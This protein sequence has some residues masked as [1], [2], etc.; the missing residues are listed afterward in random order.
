MHQFTSLPFVYFSNR[1]KG[2]TSRIPINYVFI[3]LYLEKM[4]FLFLW[5]QMFHNSFNWFDLFKEGTY[6]YRSIFAWIKTIR[7]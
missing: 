2:L 5:D 4:N 6:K 7:S 1:D 3:A